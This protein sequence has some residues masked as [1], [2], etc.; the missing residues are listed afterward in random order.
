[1]KVA[2]RLAP[3]HLT[4][5][6]TCILA[7]AFWQFG[8]VCALAETR[9]VAAPDP[10]IEAIANIKMSVAP[11]SCMRQTGAA[12]WFGGNA[13]TAFFVSSRGAF[14]TPS[15]VIELFLPGG[16]FAECIAAISVS[17][18]G[19]HQGPAVWRGEP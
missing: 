10:F 15:H 8:S 2:P 17:K 12:V 4:R 3:I 14:V 1:M 16:A 9:E 13:G 11:I 6:R 19:W 7:F 5:L 18:G